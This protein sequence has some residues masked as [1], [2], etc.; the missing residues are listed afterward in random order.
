MKKILLIP[1]DERPCNYNFPSML[2]KDTDFE[3]VMPPR[4]IMGKKKQPGD[5]DKIWNWLKENIKDCDNAVIS[6]DTLLYSGIVPSRLHNFTKEFLL[7]KLEK[8]RELK[9]INKNLTVYAFNLIMRNPT[10]SSSEEEPDY[11][12]DWGREIHRYGYINHKIELNIASEEEKTEL[13]DINKR[14][15]KKYLD[16]Y[17][18]RRAVNIEVVKEVIKLAAE[19][20]FDFVIIP[21]DDS[22]PYGLTAKDQQI[23]RQLIDDLKVNLKVYM[24]PDADAVANT[25]LA[26][27]INRLKDRRP[28]VYVKFASSVGNAVIPSYEDRIVGET[29]KYQILA[30]GGLVV[31]SVSE[32]DIVLMINIPSG[33]M[34][35]QLQEPHNGKIIQRTIE[36]DA[37]RNL[38]EFVEYAGYAAEILHKSVIIADVAYGNGGDLL[39]FSMLRQRG[40]L[41]KVASYAGWNTSSNT[42]GTCIPQGMIY[43][44]YGDTKAHKDFLALRYI[45]DLGYDSY[46][47]TEVTLQ[48]VSADNFHVEAAHG[49]TAAL[50]KEKLQKFAEEN[51]N[52]ENHKVTVKD[53]YLPWIRLFEAGIDVDVEKE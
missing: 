40:L 30:A 48:K 6:I 9:K 8:L 31:T 52:D 46:I 3:I 49:K 39:L 47:R 35:D 7:S 32:A 33:R 36:Y 5:T 43:D 50:I 17:L 20:V 22:S 45:E 12:G 37:N 11:Y 2:A 25:L 21:Q 26:R 24:Y 14:L 4:E 29:I 34:Q 28:L 23:I 41:W 38:V 27:T 1:L 10:Y 53:C 19:D 13:C 42:L 51:L 44:I 16:D 18:G 15:P